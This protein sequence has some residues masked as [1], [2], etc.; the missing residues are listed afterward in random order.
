MACVAAY[1][2]LAR[3]LFSVG[4][5]TVT[6]R[7]VPVAGVPAIDDGAGDGVGAVDDEGT[8]VAAD[9]DTPCGVAEEFLL[10]GVFNPESFCVCFGFGC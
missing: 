3:V 9:V 10:L 4:F 1:S 8:A 2:I 5:C 6:A 7:L